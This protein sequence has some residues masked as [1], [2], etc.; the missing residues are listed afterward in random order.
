MIVRTRRTSWAVA[1]LGVC[2]L[3]LLADLIGEGIVFDRQDEDVRAIAAVGSKFMSSSGLEELSRDL[4]SASHVPPRVLI[5][6]AFATSA[7]ASQTISGKGRTEMTYGEA[8]ALLRAA[9]A[10]G[11]FRMMRLFSVGDNTVMQSVNGT[12]VSRSVLV[13]ADPT[14][15]EVAGRSCEILEIYFRRLPR[16]IRPD[17]RNPLLIDAYLTTDRL[18]TVIEAEAITRNIQRLLRHQFVFAHIRSDQWFLE[19]AGFPLWYPF[20]TSVTPPTYGEYA[21]RGEVYCSSDESA[22]HCARVSFPSG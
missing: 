19:D 21:S 8:V 7:D 13:G 1:L 14:L 16:P 12:K 15:F 6:S 5:I 3:P 2:F 11:T 10:R 22:I 18:P 9:Q 4:R 20:S 17:G